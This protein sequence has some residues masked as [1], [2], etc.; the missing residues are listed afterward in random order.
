MISTT[1][2]TYYKTSTLYEKAFLEKKDWLDGKFIHC[3]E[4]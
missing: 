2:N 4:R 1:N 3:K